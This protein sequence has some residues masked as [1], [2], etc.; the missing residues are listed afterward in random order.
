VKRCLFVGY[1]EDVARFYSAMDA[2]LLPSV[3]EGTPVSVIEALAAQ[4]PAV[5]TR[6]GGTPDVIRDGV[7][8]FLVEVGDADA[9]SERLAELAGDP[10]RRAQMGAD[11]R[12]RVLGRYAVERLVDD[13]D[14]L[15][16]SLLDAHAA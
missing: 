1:Q 6:V 12:E 3:N 16:R 11:G 2:L 15:Y 8:G 14:R 10:E 9:L 4:R 7:D 5:A 13:I